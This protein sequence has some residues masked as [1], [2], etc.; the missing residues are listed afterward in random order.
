MD[1]KHSLLNVKLRLTDAQ[2]TPLKEEFVAGL[3]NLPLHTIFRQIDVSLNQN[4]ISNIGTNYPYKSYIDTILKT[5]QSTQDNILSSQLFYKDTGDNPD[6]AD[7]KTGPNSGLFSRYMATKGGKIA[8]LEGPLFLDMF[9]QS[10][11]M[12][13]GVSIGIK[14]WPSLDAFRLMSDS[15]NPNEKVQIV[16]VRFKLCVQR[17]NGGV[18][19][20]HEKLIQKQPAVYPYL[21]SEIKTA[22]VAPGQYG[23]SADD[24]FQG[25]VPTKLVVGLVSSAAYTGDYSKNPLNFR[26]YDCSSVGLYVDG[27]SYPSQP[28]QPNY[29]AGQFVDCYR[30]LTQFRN[31]INV[32]RED[33]EYGYC[34]YVLDIDPYYAFNT[35]RR[36]HCRLELKFANPL[37]ESVTLI[38]YASFPEILRIDESRSVF[39][40]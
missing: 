14:L 16:D 9:Q 18:L 15:L 26:T 33:F 20:A 5:D 35:K 32:S 39:V 38:M 13:N 7:A 11:L 27:Q 6:S 8:D 3:I 29:S 4:M 31:D 30:T 23:F 28:L 24:I 36:G 10:R 2:G 37:P 17:L 22:S 25:L 19:V 40:R 21:R 12:I 1:L 34:L